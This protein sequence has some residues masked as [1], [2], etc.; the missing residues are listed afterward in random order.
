MNSEVVYNANDAEVNDT[1]T[2]EWTW[3]FYV[4]DED[5]ILDTLLGMTANGTADATIDNYVKTE[6]NTEVG[7]DLEISITQL[8]Q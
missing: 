8:A 5:D 4:S 2:I 3:A 1:Y 7:F 6:A